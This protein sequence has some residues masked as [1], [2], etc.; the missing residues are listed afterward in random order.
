MKDVRAI[1]QAATKAM[2]GTN[3]KTIEYS[4]AGWFSRI[5]QTYGLNEDWPKYE[6]TGYTRSIDYDARWSREDY[7]RRQGNYP[8]LGGDTDGAAARRRDPE[9][10]LCLGHAERHARTA[11]ASVSRRRRRI[12]TCDNWNSR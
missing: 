9:R 12:P 4:G 8:V 6:V 5:G 7:T 11:D 2:G 3:L 1:L 10:H